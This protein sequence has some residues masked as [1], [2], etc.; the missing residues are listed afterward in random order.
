MTVNHLKWLFEN[1]AKSQ[2]IS[3]V[4]DGFVRRDQGKRYIAEIVRQLNSPTRTAVFAVQPP[5][6]FTSQ[7]GTMPPATGE[8]LQVTITDDVEVRFFPS[9]G[10]DGEST[11]I[12][13]GVHPTAIRFEDDRPGQEPIVQEAKDLTVRAHPDAAGG[14]LNVTIE[15]L[16]RTPAGATHP[17][18]GKYSE[19]VTVAMPPEMAA[20]ADRP[21][22]TYLTEKD[23]VTQGPLITS[24]DLNTLNRELM[25]MLNGLL[26]ESNSRASLAI[27]CV[28]L[29]LVG[30][31]LGM[32]FRTGNFL[33]R[34]P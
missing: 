23:P 30:G 14:V 33:A 4:V 11:L 12:V 28:I 19:V 24:L 13:N 10:V 22:S 17:T 9:E 26:A 15:L 1:P 27:S 7:A 25:V 16:G 29:V 6:S 3:S 2:K 31:S 21:I 5:R 32:M 8:Q 20:L 18:S 34:S